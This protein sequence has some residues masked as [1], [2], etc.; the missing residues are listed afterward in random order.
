[1]RT[2]SDV[3]QPMTAKQKFE[4]RALQGVC[5]PL[6]MSL[7]LSWWSNQTQNVK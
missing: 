4:N 3:K 1:M 7:T 5:R 6:W 2:H